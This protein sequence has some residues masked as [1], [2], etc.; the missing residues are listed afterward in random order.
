MAS[1]AGS[2]ADVVSVVTVAS[3]CACPYEGPAAAM[4]M[5]LPTEEVF[6]CRGPDRG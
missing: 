4:A 2:S 3:V 1:M 6:G 5:T